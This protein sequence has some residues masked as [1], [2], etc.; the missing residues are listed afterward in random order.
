MGT[1][2]TG[3]SPNANSEARELNTYRSTT[4]KGLRGKMSPF[5]RLMSLPKLFSLSL[6]KIRNQGIR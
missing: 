3:L 2:R 4:A 5:S 1:E 6:L